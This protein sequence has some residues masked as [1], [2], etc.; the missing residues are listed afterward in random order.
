MRRTDP[1]TVLEAGRGMPI[2]MAMGMRNSVALALLTLTITRPTAG[3]YLS[4]GIDGSGT[5]TA[6]SVLNFSAGQT[7]AN[8]TV[9]SLGPSGVTITNHSTG[10][11]DLIVDFNASIG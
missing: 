2:A 9:T 11:V 3:G 8:L 1:A 5:A 4:L 10:A 7:R 6:T